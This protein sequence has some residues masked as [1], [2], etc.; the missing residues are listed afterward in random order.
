MSRSPSVIGKGKPKQGMENP[1]PEPEP[2]NWLS[3]RAV[4][5]WEFNGMGKGL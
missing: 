4:G 3:V 5:A 1:S 2:K